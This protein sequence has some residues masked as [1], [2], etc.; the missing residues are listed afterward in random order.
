MIL[1]S[2]SLV[3]RSHHPLLFP[4][5]LMQW[6]TFPPPHRKLVLHRQI[7][8][9]SHHHG[10]LLVPVF[11]RGGRRYRPPYHD[12]RPSIRQSGNDERALILADAS[13][14][15]SPRFRSSSQRSSLGAG[16]YVRR[17][18]RRRPRQRREL[19]DDLLPKL[20]RQ[21]HQLPPRLFPL[22]EGIHDHVPVLPEFRQ[23]I[24]VSARPRVDG[25]GTRQALLEGVPQVDVGFPIHPGY[26]GVSSLF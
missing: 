16:G 25:A 23:A 26:V 13:H 20:P 14:A 4:Y 11:G 21:F 8:P 18:P 10:R 5:N 6:R 3:Y 9:P 1:H 24:V 19:V 7:L 17:R 15:P 2:V 22:A 12:V